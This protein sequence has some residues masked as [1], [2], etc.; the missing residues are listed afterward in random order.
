[1]AGFSIHLAVAKRYCEKNSILNISDFFKGTVDPDLVENKD[2]THYTGVRD[3]GY[4]VDYLKN[5]INL[6][7]YLKEN[8]INSDYDKGFFLHLIVDYI[9]FTD[10]FDKSYI[11]NIS[12]N[13]FIKDL[14]YSYDIVNNV[15]LYKYKIDKK[16]L[17]EKVI[18]KIDS[19]RKEKQ[20][21]NKNCKNIL[22]IKKLDA[23][24]ERVSNINLELYKDKITNVKENVL[25]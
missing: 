17:N 1:M 10:F 13:D 12:Y 20:Q 24:I 19:D 16:L 4:L 2:T 25:P 15:L 8:T 22:E 9:F 21:I 6:Y 3:T 7:K 14:Y 23:F 5:K 11:N 18:A